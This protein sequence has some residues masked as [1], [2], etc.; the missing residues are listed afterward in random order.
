MNWHKKF[1]EFLEQQ[2]IDIKKASEITGIPYSTM[3]AY[4]NGARR[5][6]DTNK[7]IIY[8]KLNFDV[9]AA[10]YGDCYGKN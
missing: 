1:K 10:I 9:V 6:S 8:K 5:P 4:L 2:K 7:E 3:C